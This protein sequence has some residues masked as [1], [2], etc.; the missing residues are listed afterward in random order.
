MHL[1]LTRPAIE[2]KAS[3]A[4][5]EALGHTVIMAPMLEIVVDSS[6]GIDPAGLT[7]VAVTSPR[8][9]RALAARDD[10][11]Q[12]SSLP[13]FAVGDRTAVVAREA[14]FRNVE[15]ASGDVEALAGLVADRCEPTD[16]TLL[17]ACGRDR[18]GDLEGNLAQ[19]GF[20]VQVAE[21]YCADAVSS[22][23]EAAQRALVDG[24]VDAVLIY[25]ARTGAVFL[26]ALARAGLR[27]CLSRLTVLA[28]S[29]AAAEPF[30]G[31]DVARIAIAVRPDE[32]S[33]L[34][35]VVMIR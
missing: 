3:A 1:L 28:I 13:L 15:S 2:A 22:L 9:V 21:V 18:R 5:L 23:S 8:A 20:M 11:A 14:G 6:V 25:S 7:A 35:L 30:G 27:D 33:L 29:Q 32:A 31:V 26:E 16:G 10:F 12:L 19:K 17:Y 4:R 34:D 24:R